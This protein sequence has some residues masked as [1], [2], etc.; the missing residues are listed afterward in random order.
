[1]A[2]GVAGALATALP[3]TPL[4][5]LTRVFEERRASS[6]LVVDN[7]RLVGVV[8][9]ADLARIPLDDL[10]LARARQVMSRRV[11]RAFPDESLY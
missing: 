11:L 10:D 3:D 6:V 5:A 9:A 7:G 8:T 2:D 1:M 4:R